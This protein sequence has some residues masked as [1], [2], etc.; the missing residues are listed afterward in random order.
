MINRFLSWPIRV[1][2]I[3][4]IAL[5]AIPSISLIIYSG[6]AERREAI[7]GA[8]IEC[9][10]FVNDVASQQAAIVTG[11]EQLGTALAL[12]P[13]IQSQNVDAVTGLFSDLLKKNPQ[14]SNIA[15]CDNSGT[16]WASAVAL[17][18]KVSIAD[19]RFFREA[20]RTGMFSS[21]E[22]VMSRATKTPVLSFGYPV[23]NNA[24]EVI[25]VIG[26]ILNLDYSRA[27]SKGLTSRLIR[28]STCSI[29]KEL[30]SVQIST[31]RFRRNVSAS[32]TSHRKPSP[33]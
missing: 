28:R 5:L 6:M 10:K 27:F 4:L 13:A 15:I 17:D 11:A 2:L 12:L 14:Y 3:V 32:P 8:K 18:G 9:L 16:V 21:G 23:K 30:S 25:A 31:I 19:R 33:G 26:I 29:T 24:N 7:A 20:T 22:Y 1:H